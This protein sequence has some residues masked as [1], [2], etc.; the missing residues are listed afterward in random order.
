MPE[1]SID[2]YEQVVDEFGS[3]RRVQ[4]FARLFM[5]PGLW[6]CGGGPGPDLVDPFAA[7]V[8]WVEDGDAPDRLAAQQV[9]DG[10]VTATRPVCAYPY[11]ARYDG[12]GDPDEASS[13]DCKPNYGRPG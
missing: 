13:Y 12:K 2:Y 10:E 1:G 4:R 11:V 3:R 6:H 8:A 7:L 9:V 5:V